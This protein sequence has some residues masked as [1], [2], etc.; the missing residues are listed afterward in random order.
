MIKTTTIV[1]ALFDIGRDK[2]SNYGLSYHTY[3]MWMKNLLYF[4]TN[5]V[6]YTEEKFKNFIIEQRKKI[7]NNLEKTIIIIDNLENLDTYK[8]FY[9]KV[10]DLMED[11]DFKNK[12]HFNV[13]EM[14]EPLYNI[15]IFNK[16]Y[17]IKNAIE[18][19]YFN[20]D[21]FIWCDAGVL[22][23]N[24]FEHKKEFPNVEKINQGYNDKVTFFS[25]QIDFTINDRPFHLL[26]QFRYIHGGCFFVPS[27]NK[28]DN[29]IDKFNVLVNQY[30]KTGY[31]GSEE[32]YLDF[33][34]LDN[35]DEY[36]IVKSDWRQYFDIFG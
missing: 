14:T 10:K 27:N 1:T 28:I 3:M 26:S 33:C 4:D 21:M 29:L 19:K 11:V 9:K 16:L 17:F 36:N 32:K 7:D 34:F 25:H 15:I 30:L 20:S 31:V 24:N 35:K 13:P 6:I 8:L 23:D 12:K 2:W 22:R 5:M 18:N